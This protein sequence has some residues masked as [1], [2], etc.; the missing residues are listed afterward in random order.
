M[1]ALLIGIFLAIGL[2]RILFRIPLY[3]IIGI[4]YIV[5]FVL[6]I[7]I[8]PKLHGI[9]F[10]ISGATTGA[11]TVPF[12]LAI[13]IGVASMQ[14]SGKSAEKDSFGLIGIASSGAIIACLI[15]LIISNPETMSLEY[16]PA[17]SQHGF[18]TT[19]FEA[20]L[21]MAPIFAITLLANLLFFKIKFKRF[22]RYLFGFLYAFIGLSFFLYGVYSGFLSV[23]TAIGQS[24]Q[25]DTLI[26]VI[27]ISFL[28][29]VFA[30][31][32]EPA[33][34]I[35]TSQIN[36][37]T[38]GSVSKNLVVVSLALGVGIA[39]ILNVLRI[40]IDD[41]QLWY[42][43]LPGYVIAL[44]LMFFAPKLFVGM[45]FDAGGVASGPVAATFIFAFSQGIAIGAGSTLDIADAFGMIALIALMPIITIEILGVIYK[46]KAKK[47]S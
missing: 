2:I 47:R 37:V 41:F 24:I 29:G 21:A 34:Y 17:T 46:V 43:L 25:N 36:D 26:L 3:I 33:V 19:M 12:V 6:V 22:G 45:A 10:D 44:G 40:Q 31:L 38:A 15:L 42:V 28:L 1:V 16:S 27:A 35:L 14:R 30:I 18:F 9:A 13:A 8:S 20:F 5:I 32:A 11:I 4:A 39:L 7:F 23:G